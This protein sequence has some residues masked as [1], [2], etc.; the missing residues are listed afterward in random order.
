MAERVFGEIPGVPPGTPFRDRREL[1]DRG[2]HR[3]LQ[4]GISGSGREGAD[5]IVVSGGYEDDE[6]LGEVIV[7]T[8]HGGN[9]PATG[10]QIADQ[11]LERGN[12][13]LAHNATEGLPLRVIRGAGGEPSISPSSGYR[14]DGLFSVVRFWQQVGRSGFRVWRYR[15]ER[16][17]AQPDL[18]PTPSDG[19]ATPGRT[20][21]TVQRIVRSTALAIQVKELHGH[22]CQVCGFRLDT[23]AGPYAEGAHLRPLGRPHD[24]PD[25]LDNILCL[26]PTDHVRLDHGAIVLT[27]ELEIVETATRETVGRLRIHPAHTVNLGHVA[28]HRARFGPEG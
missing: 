1:H 27:D 14:Y 19:A 10:K 24:G 25:A 2:V 9:D 16:T 3:P 13:A 22:E 20:L 15:L 11:R 21:T 5:S 18:G 8:G 12:L 23:P 6:D 4:A 7:Y 26:C 28:Y 17:D